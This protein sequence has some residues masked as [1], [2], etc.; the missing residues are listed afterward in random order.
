MCNENDIYYYP[1][2]SG[3]EIVGEVDFG[4]CYEFDKFVVWR[5]KDTGRLGYAQDCGCSCPSPFEDYGPEHIEWTD[6][7][8]IS[9]KLQEVAAEKR[10][11]GYS[12]NPNDVVFLIDKVV[13]PS[14]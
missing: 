3:L 4:E 8:T 7:R 10:R 2:K 13:N 5:E 1:E 14:D 6:P 12:F 11:W 9:L